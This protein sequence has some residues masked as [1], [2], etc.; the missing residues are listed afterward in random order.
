MNICA[1]DLLYSR[2]I[3]LFN[4]GRRGEAL[5][6][7]QEALLEDFGLHKMLFTELPHLEEDND[8]L[9]IITNY[10]V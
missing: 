10:Q 1:V 9:R 2:V 3:C 4:L 7:L 6:F 8:V 5:Y